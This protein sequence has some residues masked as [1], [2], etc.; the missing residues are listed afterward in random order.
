MHIGVSF[1][2]QK[3]NT[4]GV[5]VIQSLSDK[6]ECLTDTVFP[7]LY[8]MNTENGWVIMPNDTRVQPILAYSTQNAYFDVNDIP[9]GLRCLLHDYDDAVRFAQDSLLD[10]EEGNPEWEQ[11]STYSTS[12]EPKV[13]LERCTEVLW[14]QDENNDTDWRCTPSYNQLCPTFYTPACGHTYVGCTAV[15]MGQIMWYYKWPYYA[16]VPNSISEQGDP[17]SKTHLQWYDWNKMPS[18]L[19]HNTSSDEANLVATLLRDCGYAAKMKYRADGSGAG[20]K[21]AMEALSSTFGYSSHISYRKKSLTINWIKKIKAEIDAGRPVLYAAYKK[22]GGGHSFVIDGYEGNRFHINWG[23]GDTIANNGIYALELLK[24]ESNTGIHYSKDHE[25]LFG[26]EPSVN[27]S[28][29]YSSGTVA[30]NASYIE[31]GGENITL[32]NFTIESSAECHIYSGTQIRLT[33]GFVAKTGSSAHF[34][35]C[36]VPCNNTLSV[37]HTPAYARQ[38]KRKK[39]KSFGRPLQENS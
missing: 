2:R 36:D 10:M 26:I 3:A 39:L 24:P 1:L 12:E 11:I 29:L 25:A 8:I 18:V 5:P 13:L 37:M 27:C 32:G 17:S 34:A 15:A 16:V 22:E 23:W 35:I 38:C 28:P 21:D 20:L 6:V 30:S 4:I 7:H 33:D 19:Y 31:V 9:D 14:N